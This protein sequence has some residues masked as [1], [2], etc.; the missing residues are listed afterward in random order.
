M[1]KSRRRQRSVRIVVATSLLVVAA[2]AVVP[3]A[4]AANVAMLIPSSLFAVLAGFCALRI[5]RNEILQTRRDWA[6]DR[7]AQAQSYQ[8]LA[9]IRQAEHDTFATAMTERLADRDQTIVTL[10]G[11]LKLSERRAD[12]A[13][14][15]AREQAERAAEL[16]SS[17]EDMTAEQA[18][19]VDALATWDGADLP[20][21]VDLMSWEQTTATLTQEPQRKEA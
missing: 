11:T 2:L 18:A 10:R 5:M 4:I 8:E 7:A 17:V 9:V 13:E 12:D 1:S 16:Q 21:I 6:A 20:T 14:R 19:S 15:R 3:S